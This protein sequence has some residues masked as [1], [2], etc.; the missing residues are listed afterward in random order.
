MTPID[1]LPAPIL[2]LGVGNL[3]LRDDGVGLELLEQLLP[4]ILH[5]RCVDAVD[6]GTQGLA[7]LPIL[8]ERQSLLVL[9][10][11]ARGAAPGTV[12]VIAD[13]RAERPGR[14]RTAHESNAGDLIAAAEL[15]GDCPE[16]IVVV[17]IEPQE[18]RTGIG[19]SP[20]VREA[21]PRAL[22]TARRCLAE[23][24]EGAEVTVCTS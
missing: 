12:H 1:L 4:T 18:V 20:V 9:D 8:A 24:V 21:V 7:L 22:D 14:G 11:V 16:R 13:A 5:A 6:G 15:I 3:L 19:L 17:G 10:A 23:L 2:V